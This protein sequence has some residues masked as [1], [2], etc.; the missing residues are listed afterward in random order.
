MFGI[1]IPEL[2]VILIIALLI[3]GPNKL[4]EIA[5]AIGKGF[6]DFKKA[7]E[8]VKGSIEHE[9]T[10]LDEDRKKID[11]DMARE[12]K[13]KKKDNTEALAKGDSKAEK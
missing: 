8:D 3:F 1:G 9:I 7:A 11:E 10:K 6:A 12:T 5:R 13:E 4:P 2:I